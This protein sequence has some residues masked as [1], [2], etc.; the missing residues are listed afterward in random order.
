MFYQTDAKKL[1]SSYIAQIGF[2]TRAGNA[3]GGARKTNQDSYLIATNIL[4]LDEFSIFAV[5]D[6][7]GKENHIYF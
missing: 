1:T 2:K 5:F 7:H 3:P 4:G 6:G